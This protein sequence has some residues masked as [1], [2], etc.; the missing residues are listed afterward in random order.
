MPVLTL[1]FD[2]YLIVD[3]KMFLGCFRTLLLPRGDAGVVR[4]LEA[5]PV[6]VGHGVMINASQHFCKGESM[7]HTVAY[8]ILI[9]SSLAHKTFSLPLF[10]IPFS[11]TH[12][13][14]DT[15]SRA[16]QFAFQCK[17]LLA[18]GLWG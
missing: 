10:T 8:I 17:E 1:I 15:R 6:R 3:L 12:V 7:V 16:H 9:V 11:P 4:H 18:L 2:A 14:Y 5:T 13:R